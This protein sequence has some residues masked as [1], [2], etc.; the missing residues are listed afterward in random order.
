M[1]GESASIVD[2]ISNR[3]WYAWGLK[4][5]VPPQRGR[6]P[7]RIRMHGIYEIVSHP[8]SWDHI[9]SPLLLTNMVCFE[10]LCILVPKKGRS[11]WTF[12]HPGGRLARVY[13]TPT[14]QP[15]AMVDTSIGNSAKL[16]ALFVSWLCRGCCG[17]QGKLVGVATRAQRCRPI[18]SPGTVTHFRDRHLNSVGLPHTPNHQVS[19]LTNEETALCASCF[20]FATLQHCAG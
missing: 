8:L 7:W 6:S 13:S 17:R 20:K 4:I 14:S 1:G 2:L 15:A 9:S 12:A 10:S 19:R 18:H 16:P 5:S 11:L 3:I